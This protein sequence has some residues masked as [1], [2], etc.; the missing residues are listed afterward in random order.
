MKEVKLTTIIGFLCF[1]ALMLAG[2][3]WLLTFIPG[4][5]LE[6]TLKWLKNI[7]VLI[8]IACGLVFGWMWLYDSKMNKTLKIVLMTLFVLFAV[9][10]VIGVIR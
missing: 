9:L 2:T 3:V 5:A 10:A 7:S 6:N 8:L 1:I 4:N